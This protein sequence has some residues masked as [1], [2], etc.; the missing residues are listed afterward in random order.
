MIKWW[1]SCRILEWLNITNVNS[2]YCMK[3]INFLF[4]LKFIHYKDALFKNYDLRSSDVKKTQFWHQNSRYLKSQFFPKKACFDVSRFTLSRI[5]TS[6][7]NMTAL[8][9]VYWLFT[10]IVYLAIQVACYSFDAIFD[11]ITNKIGRL[12]YLHIV[13]STQK[14]KHW[15]DGVSWSLFCC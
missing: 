5:F 2:E 3:S 1:P 6:D 9:D 8:S 15:K 4:C 10:T 13:K 7:P 14:T 12:F 11:C